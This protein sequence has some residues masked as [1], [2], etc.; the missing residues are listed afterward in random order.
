LLETD[1]SDFAI[2]GI[3]S[4][5]FEYG[6]IHPVQ[7]VSRKLS[8]AELNYDVY[9]KEML[10]V[11]FSLRK[12]RHYLQG[13]E[14]KTTIFSDH[15]NRMYFISA[16]LLNRRQ[17]RWADELTQYNFQLLY[18]KGSS[19]AQADI[20][21]RCPEF[22]S[23]EGGT[24]STTNQTML[25]KE[26]WLEVGAMELVC[27]EYEAIQIL[28]ID[29]DQLLPEA[30]ERIKEKAMLDE[31][32][33]EWCKQVTVGGNIDKGFSISNEL[34]CWKN[35]IYVPEGL[36]QRIIQSEHDS[37]VAEHFGRERTLELVTRNFYWANME[38]DIRKYCNECDICPR[39]KAP[40]HAKHGLLHPRELACKPWMHIST[41]FVTDLP[42]SEGAA[43]ILVV[44]DRFTKMA[45]FVPVNKKDSPTVACAYLENIWKYHGFPEDV[46]SDRDT[47]FMGSFFTALYCYLGIKCGMSM[48]YHPQTNGQMERIN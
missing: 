22:T 39:T 46:V 24:T 33:R 2:A 48:A 34:L 10:A 40:R 6:K 4:Q 28:A 8:P 20:L 11:I 12:N 26:Q 14:H 32:Y 44:V 35:R 15:Q 13:A 31:K 36:R 7:F 16:I 25:D 43:R 37:K 30:R 18:R 27:D 45:H 3:P 17:A 19:N 29:V 38:H 5:K 23:R 21:S 1:A 42:E 9:D 47:T 41:D